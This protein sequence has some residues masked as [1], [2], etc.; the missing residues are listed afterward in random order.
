MADSNIE[1]I[2][3]ALGML[4]Q[5]P[6]ASLDEGTKQATLAGL[7]WKLTFDEVLRAHPWN[8][9]I[10][11]I[12]LS[13]L[14]DTPAFGYSNAFKLP[15]DWLR[16]L[17][18][19]AD[20]FRMEGGKILCNATGLDL[21]YIARVTDITV[22]DSLFIAAVSACMASKMAFPIVNSQAAQ[23]AMW[24]IYTAQLAQAR[25][26]D[27]QEEPAEELEASSLLSVRG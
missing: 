3:Q 8:F 15:G 16:T 4:G 19:S 10:T 2:N 22:C 25:A 12:H 27:S 17:E 21:R 9:A 1:I 5:T 13:P 20:D 6:I 26:V 11:R 24:Q 14:S 7:F 23:Q 18:C